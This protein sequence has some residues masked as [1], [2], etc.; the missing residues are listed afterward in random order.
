MLPLFPL[1]EGGSPSVALEVLVPDRNGSLSSPLCDAAVHHQII[2][3]AQSSLY[4]IMGTAMC[5]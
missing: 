4:N 2:H 5:I 1:A 3:E